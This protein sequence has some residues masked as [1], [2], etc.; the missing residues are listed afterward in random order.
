MRQNGIHHVTAIA[1]P[2]Q[3]NLDFYTRTLGLRLVKKTVNFD[4]PSTFHFYFGDEAGQPGTILTFFPWE[5]AAPG[6]LGIGETQ[7]TVFRVPEGSIG[8]WTH[9]LVE[10]GV[11]HEVPQ[12]RFGETVL[13]FKDPDGMRLALVAVPG[14]EGEPAWSDGEVPVEHAIR[15]FHSVSLLLDKA[16]PTGAILTDVF[17]FTEIGREE[18]VTRYKAGD[19]ALGGI[20]D[21]RE[22][23]GFLP[24]RPGAGTVHHIAFRAEN[25]EVQAQMV[26]KLL[27]NHGIRAT[28]QKDRDYFRAVYFREPGGLLFEI[29]TDAPGF[30]VDEPADAL[31]QALKLPRFLEPNRPAIEA[32]LPKVA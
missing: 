28:E 5:H 30:A 2:A 24:G 9:R 21:L 10:K 31:G 7:E 32:V 1:G 16:A 23:G 27:R 18:S 17:G 19:T 20:V 12:K 6:R 3:R 4:D 29:A 14:I 13:A 26:E 11:S 25:D 8:Y 15:G 22:A